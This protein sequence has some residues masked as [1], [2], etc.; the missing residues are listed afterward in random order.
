MLY[1]TEDRIQVLDSIRIELTTSAQLVR[2][3]GYLRDHSGDEGK[4]CRIYILLCFC[5]LWLDMLV[6]R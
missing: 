4:H 6:A 2:V 3:S 5:S 1:A